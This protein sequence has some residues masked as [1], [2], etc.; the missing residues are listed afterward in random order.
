MNSTSEWDNNV[1]GETAV[2][3]VSVEKD[4]EVYL[5][6]TSLDLDLDLIIED[7]EQAQAF[8]DSVIEAKAE[9]D[10]R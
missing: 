6:L 3:E 9:W 1:G 2:V 7:D 4:V 10:A 8:F 5:N